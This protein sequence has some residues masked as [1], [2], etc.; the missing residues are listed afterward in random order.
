M[1]TNCSD[2]ATATS[3]TRPIDHTL[4][5]MISVGVTGIA[6]RCSM[7]PCSRSRISAAPHSRIDTIVT[8]LM[9]CV[10]APNQPLSSVGLKRARSASS[11]GAAVRPCW[12]CTKAAT[13]RCTICWIALEPLKAC[14]M[15]VAS[16]FNCSAGW[17]PA[18]TSR[19][20]FTGMTSAK[21]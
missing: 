19:W 3:T 21:V 2:A 10:I 12:R 6:S 18:S 16:T 17:R 13:S 8:W 20:K 15:R 5:S 11:T 14:V 9:S 1:T 4:D 7:V